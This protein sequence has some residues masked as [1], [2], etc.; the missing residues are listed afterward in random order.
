[1]LRKVVSLTV[2][3]TIEDLRGGLW[4]AE[5][6]AAVAQSILRLPPSPVQAPRAKPAPV[7][8][9]PGQPQPV[10]VRIAHRVERA[11]HVTRSARAQGFRVPASGPASAAPEAPP[12]APGR[13]GV[14]RPEQNAVFVAR[15]QV[16]SSLA[17]R[18]EQEIA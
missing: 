6:D 7:Q 9:T 3:D 15:L 18:T 16:L 2:V 14:T 17:R 13:T 12:R 4:G 8:P 11:L 5:I 1:M 10:S